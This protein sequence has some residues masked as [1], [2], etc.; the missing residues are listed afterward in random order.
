MDLMNGASE[1]HPGS[2]P[3]PPPHLACALGEL[4]PLPEPKTSFIR[5]AGAMLS[6]TRAPRTPVFQGLL[7]MKLLQPLTR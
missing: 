6:G 5:E 7:H 2:N 3:S 4:L 1:M